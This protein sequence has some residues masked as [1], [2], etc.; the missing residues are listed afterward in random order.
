MVN[1]MMGANDSV[2]DNSGVDTKGLDLDYNKSDYSEDEIGAAEDALADQIAD[3]GIV[4][5]KNEDNALP[6][7]KDTPISFFSRNSVTVTTHAGIMGHGS[8]SL[9]EDFEATAIPS[10]RLFGSSMTRATDHLMDLAQALSVLVMK[11][12]LPS[13]SAR[14]KRSRQ[15]TRW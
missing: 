15:T 4:L 5:L 9:K 10:I 11:K 12:T 6:L 1:A 13:M 8:G 14:W 2:I 7:S 3:E